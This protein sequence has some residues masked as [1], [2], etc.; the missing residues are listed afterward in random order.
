[1]FTLDADACEGTNMRAS[2]AIDH[3][4][5]RL[6]HLDWMSKLSNTSTD[7]GG[8]GIFV[9]LFQKLRL[10]NR[11]LVNAS[12]HSCMTHGFCLM[13]S[14]EITKFYGASGARNQNSMQLIYT[15]HA[16][17]QLF[18]LETWHELWTEINNQI[19]HTS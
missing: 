13:F 12:F 2:Q 1:M 9:G 3:L 4:M 6:D 5:V 8:G 16:L 17:E 15:C 19:T 10:L 18:E 14:N 11:I 7:L